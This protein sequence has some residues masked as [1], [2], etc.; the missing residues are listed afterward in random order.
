MLVH[1]ARQW[2]EYRD[3]NWNSEDFA[4]IGEDFGQET[5]Q[6]TYGKTA[7]AAAQLI[8]QRELVDYAVKWLEHKRV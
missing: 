2:V 3:F 8:P 5:G 7:A 4:A 1:G 6:I